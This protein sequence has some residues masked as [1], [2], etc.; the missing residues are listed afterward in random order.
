MGYTLDVI[1]GRT[2]PGIGKNAPC[3]L[4][5]KI[6]RN[7]EINAPRKIEGSD[8]VR[9][10]ECTTRIRE[11]ALCEIWENELCENGRMYYVL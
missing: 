3:A 6:L 5:K 2:R 4:G 7:I 8:Y 10:G 11:N 9:R 1:W